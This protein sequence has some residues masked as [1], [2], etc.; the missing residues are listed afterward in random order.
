MNRIFLDRDGLPGGGL[1][2]AISLFIRLVC[3]LIPRIA[4]FIV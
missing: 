1:G 3:G 2:G 4:L